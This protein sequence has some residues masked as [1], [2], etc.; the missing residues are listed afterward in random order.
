MDTNGNNTGADSTR[1]STLLDGLAGEADYDTPSQLPATQ[2][3][4]ALGTYGSF[5][6]DVFQFSSQQVCEKREGS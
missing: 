1:R 2:S 6:D 5:K 4:S 3:T